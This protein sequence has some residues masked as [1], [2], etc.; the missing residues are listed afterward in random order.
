M[1]Q[2]AALRVLRATASVALARA[3]SDWAKKKALCAAAS[4]ATTMAFV[5]R[6]PGMS[7]PKIGAGSTFNTK[8]FH[9]SDVLSEF[10]SICSEALNHV[11]P[12]NPDLANRLFPTLI[13][14]EQ[15]DRTSC[16]ARLATA[17]DKTATKGLSKYASVTN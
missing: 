14:L 3:F 4:A 9:L 17:A 7:A 1:S 16:R 8:L 13:A 10:L 15:Y 6:R 2:T 11:L 5:E 12:T